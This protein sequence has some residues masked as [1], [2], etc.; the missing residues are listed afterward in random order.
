MSEDGRIVQGLYNFGHRN[1]DV[2]TRAQDGLHLWFL[3]SVYPPG[4]LSTQVINLFLARIVCVVWLSE[5]MICPRFG[6]WLYIL[7]CGAVLRLLDNGSYTCENLVL[8]LRD[9]L[10]PSSNTSVNYCARLLLL[11]D[12]TNKTSDHCC[13]STV[14]EPHFLYCHTSQHNVKVLHH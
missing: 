5:V 11:T 10:L 9:D 8:P 13:K 7:I 3:Y 6:R 2:I 14:T 1:L 4:V 12:S